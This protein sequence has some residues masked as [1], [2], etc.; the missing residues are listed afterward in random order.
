MH[1]DAPVPDEV[2]N[3]F[4]RPLKEELR[5]KLIEA[6]AKYHA[7]GSSANGPNAAFS[8]LLASAVASDAMGSDTNAAT[9]IDDG[10]PR[11]HDV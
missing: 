1:A 3:A 11:L 4:G 2:K 8:C 9:A 10:M 6:H 5:Q 7:D